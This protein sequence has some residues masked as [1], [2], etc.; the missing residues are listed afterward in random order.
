MPNAYP[1]DWRKIVARIRDRAGSRCERCHVGPGEPYTRFSGRVVSQKEFE[2]LGKE[3]PRAR[4][5]RLKL[6]EEALLRAKER[7]LSPLI[8]EAETSGDYD[9]G[10]FAE[11]QY[12]PFD[13]EPLTSQLI[14]DSNNNCALHFEVHH[15]DKD[16]SNNDD[17][18][19]EYLCKRCH[20][21]KHKH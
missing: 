14:A 20:N 6:H 9:H 1:K 3:A 5:Q 17:S 18:N 8:T 13:N 4:R 12:Y 16:K 10:Y 2:R 15:I 21:F 19:L 7:F 11:G